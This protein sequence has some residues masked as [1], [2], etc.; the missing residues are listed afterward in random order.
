MVA[1]GDINADFQEI[2][3]PGIF[4]ISPT[5]FKIS[6]SLPLAAHKSSKVMC[7]ASPFFKPSDSLIFA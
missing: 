2:P 4:S 6:T 5:G 3:S 1:E 7:A